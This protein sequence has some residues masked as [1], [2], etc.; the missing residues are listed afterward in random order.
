MNTLVLLSLAAIVLS[1]TAALIFTWVERRSPTLKNEGRLLLGQPAKPPTALL[2]ALTDLFAHRPHVRAAYLAQ[3]YAPSSDRFPH[4]VIGLEVDRDLH[5]IQEEAGLLCRHHLK[6]GEFID[7][8]PIGSDAVS[9]YMKNQ[10]TPF[11]VRPI[12]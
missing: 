1:V 11:F 2:A 6:D 8:I 4:P 12:A 3:V 10:T 7:F 5:A 9:T